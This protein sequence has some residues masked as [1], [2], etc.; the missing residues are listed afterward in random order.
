MYQAGPDP[1]CYPGTDV[2]RNKA[3]LTSAEAL[4]AFETRT[5]ARSEE[6]LPAG[7]LP[8]SHY[9]AIHHHLFHDV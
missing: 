3:G 8:V 6:P 9:R 5:F 2:L 1:Y 7:R 4:E